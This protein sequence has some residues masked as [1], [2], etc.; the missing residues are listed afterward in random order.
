MRERLTNME[1]SRGSLRVHRC[2]GPFALAD[3]KGLATPVS[4][5]DTGVAKRTVRSVDSAVAHG[6]GKSPEGSLSVRL[7][8]LAVESVTRSSPQTHPLAAG[9]V[10]RFDARRS[11]KLALGRTVI[12]GPGERLR[13]GANRRRLASRQAQIGRAHV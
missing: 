9:A 1:R 6:S 12:D 4:S 3:A 5:V 2:C 7:H 10:R 11:R 13:R 8:H